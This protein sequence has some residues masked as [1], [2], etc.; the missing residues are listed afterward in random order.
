MKKT[1]AIIG[2]G[3]SGLIMLK[4]ALEKLPD[5]EV[6]CFE[7]GDSIRGCWGSLGED[8]LSTSTKYT[9]QFSCFREFEAD[10]DPS[11]KQ[12]E[13]FRG[14]EYGDYL[15]RFADAFD[16]RGSIQLNARVARVERGAG[17]WQVTFEDGVVRQF[18]HV[19]ICTG[20][21]QQAEAL[22]SE[23]PILQARCE[24]EK[25]QGKTVVVMG[26]GEAAAE[27]ANQLAR[28][29]KRNQVYLSLRS[30]IRVSPRYHPIK[31]V[32]SDFLRNRLMLSIRRSWRNRIGQKFVESRIRFRS[33]FEQVF[34][35]SNR[36]RAKGSQLGR[37]WDSRLAAE[38][39]DGLFNMFHNKSDG[40]LQAVGEERVKIVGPPVDESGKTFR[41]FASEKECRV[42]A[43]L[44]VPS[45]GFQSGLKR[46]FGGTIEVSQFY[47]GC[48]HRD[49]KDLFLIGFA[50]PVL[51]NIPSI[52]EQQALYVVAHLAGEL[53]RGES[54]QEQY[55]E[56]REFLARTYPC[57]NLEKVYPVEMFSYCDQ[58][59]RE[60]GMLPSIR[61]V[62]S[63]AQWL[64][65][66]LSPATTLHY[67]DYEQR[68]EQVYTPLALNGLLG[69][70]RFADLVSQN[71]PRIVGKERGGGM[72]TTPVSEP[73][74]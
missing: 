9:T 11:G 53:A 47:R 23:L 74:R 51:G 40:F 64:R 44:M 61:A 27:V 1:L 49:Y 59:A 33:V 30:G 18:S 38:A 19:A 55:Q 52:S 15:E 4:S 69:V 57:V 58:L 43:D 12:G 8:F 5:W 50:R 65:I 34:P 21:V 42:E 13:F 28:P 54:W 14:R 22:K 41:E 39:K 7:G 35:S 73:S 6:T 26:G 56:E 10:L 31:G 68:T 36:P 66:Q 2:A 3:S 25:V 37:D 62:S 45:I 72:D 20:L 60:R 67:L 29:E 70:I 46:L 16:L 71:L 63:L 24:W 32:P 17:G 48:L